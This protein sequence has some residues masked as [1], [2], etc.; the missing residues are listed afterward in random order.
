MQV[1][2]NTKNIICFLEQKVYV[3]WQIVSYQLVY[4]SGVFYGQNE[5]MYLAYLAII[6]FIVV[7]FY[8]SKQ[9]KEDLFLMVK[10]IFLALIG[11]SFCLFLGFFEFQSVL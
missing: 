4:L 5:N 8:I 2:F 3:L 10:V 1:K 9:K 7:H 11:E 6:I